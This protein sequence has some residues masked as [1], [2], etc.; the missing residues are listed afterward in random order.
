MDP[1]VFIAELEPTVERSLERHLTSAKEWFPHQLVPWSRGRDFVAG[2]VWDPREVDL[3][4]GVRSALLV[5]LLTE[6]NL[7]YY[8]STLTAQ[9]GND[10]PWGVW[11]RR[12]TAE[13]GRH[14]IVLR[15]YL[16]VTR[17]LDPVA[18]ERARMAQVECGQVPRLAGP[19]NGLIYVTLQE[20]ATRV[21][22]HNT[23]K[24]LDDPAGRE[25][26]KRVAADEN[27]HYLFYREL[28]DAAFQLDPSAMVIALEHEVRTFE[29]PGTGI[30]D[31]SHHAKAI[32]RAGIYDF[33][34][35][36]EQILLPVVLR[37]WNVEALTG[38]TPEAEEA[39]ESVLARIER[40]AQAGR[41]TAARREKAAVSA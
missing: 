7:P 26:M 39:R 35:H 15:D 22:H 14:S 32:A 9:Y 23:G 16:T 37:H 19:E 2:E 27:R 11:A 1:A 8:T 4:G 31:F 18:L 25:I 10:G 3:A 13:E 5:N 33:R 36:Y 38:L 34:I 40:I 21:A 41:R 20:L 12:W 28:A 6:D 30:L 17:A 29:M 24:Q